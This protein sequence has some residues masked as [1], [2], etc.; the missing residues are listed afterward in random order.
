MSKCKNCRC[1]DCWPPM[2]KEQREYEK[3]R[4]YYKKWM[5]EMEEKDKEKKEKKEKKEVE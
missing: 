4:P 3:S 1:A 5:N 2:T